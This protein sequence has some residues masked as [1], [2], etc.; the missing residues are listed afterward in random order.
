MGRMG[1]MGLIGLMSPLVQVAM[2]NREVH[3]RWPLKAAIIA[4]GKGTPVRPLAGISPGALL[5][6]AGRPIVLRQLAF[7]AHYGVRE[8]AVL[9]GPLADALGE[10][11]RPEARRLGMRLEFLVQPEPL[12]AAGGLPAAGFPGRRRL[13]RDPRRR[14][15]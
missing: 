13:L 12:A 10:A 3:R 15:P 11:M 8:V 6:V 2:Q 5:P 7:L 14:G 4:G 9:A 1:R